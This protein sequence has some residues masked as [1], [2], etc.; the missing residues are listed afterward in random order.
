MVNWQSFEYLKK[1]FNTVVWWEFFGGEWSIHA[2]VLQTAFVLETIHLIFSYLRYIS[3]NI[4][5]S[6]CPTFSPRAKNIRDQ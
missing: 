6:Y 5:L 2:G 1:N 4:V 3:R